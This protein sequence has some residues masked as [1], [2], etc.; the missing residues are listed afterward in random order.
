MAAPFPSVRV[1][2]AKLELM[3][4]REGDEEEEGMDMMEW[5]SEEE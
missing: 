2:L 1:R 3:M 5:V 4:E